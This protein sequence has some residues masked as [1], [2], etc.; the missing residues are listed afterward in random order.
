MMVPELNGGGTDWGSIAAIRAVLTVP[1][2]YIYAVAICYTLHK[3]CNRLIQKQ[4]MADCE[5]TNKKINWHEYYY[6]II[7]C[8][9]RARI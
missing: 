1:G 2:H 6:K 7:K 9:Y 4:L 8:Y 5:A 3:L